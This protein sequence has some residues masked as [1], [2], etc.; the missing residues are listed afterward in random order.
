MSDLEKKGHESLFV[1]YEIA[2]DI[3]ELGF[4]EPFSL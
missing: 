2:L 4:D 1:P 3:K